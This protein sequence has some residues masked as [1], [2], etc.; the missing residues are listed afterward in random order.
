MELLFT[1]FTRTN[2]FR[3]YS[4]AQKQVLA[5]W[6]RENTLKCNVFREV[7]QNKKEEEGEEVENSEQFVATL[8]LCLL[9]TEEDSLY[10]NQVN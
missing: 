7:S 6:K 5:Y 4:H 8:N 2:R 10:V 1:T 3:S 9:F